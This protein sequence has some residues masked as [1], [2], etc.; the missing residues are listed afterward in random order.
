LT[1]AVSVAAAVAALA[2]QPALLTPSSVGL[3]PGMY[4]HTFMQFAMS[5]YC[6]FAPLQLAMMVVQ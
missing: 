1:A 2:L 3:P 6:W 5:A 4:E